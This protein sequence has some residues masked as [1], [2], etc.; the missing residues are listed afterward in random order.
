MTPER[1]Q[2][3][4]A[5]LHAA[6]A[7]PTT[8]RGTYLAGACAGDDDLLRE[9]ESLLAQLSQGSG[10][11]STPAL[12]LGAAMPGRESSLVGRQLGRYVVQER[13]GSGGMGEVYRAEDTQLR[14]TVALKALHD[15][16]VISPEGRQRLLREAQAVAALNHPNIAAIYDLINI[17]SDA[18][19]PPHIVMEYVPGETLSMRLKRGP[20]HVTEALRVGREVADALAAT[21]KRGIIHRD[22]KPANLQLTADGRVKV[23][24]FGLAR[25][26]ASPVDTTNFTTDR[27]PL[28][29]ADHRIAGTPGYMSPEQA[30]GRPVG[31]PTDVF[32]LGIVLFEMLTGHRPY[33]GEEVLPVSLAMIS[34][35]TPQVQGRR[36]EFTSMIDALVTRMLAIE[37]GDR[38]TAADI[39]S[40]FD[41]LLR[42]D[43]SDVQAPGTAPRR[44]WLSSEAAV[45]AVAMILATAGVAWWASRG[46]APDRR[47]AIAV[48]PLVNL[49]GDATQDYIGIGI[50]ET[51]TTS[52]ARVRSV[53]VISR[54]GL[55]DLPR[56]SADARTIAR[57]VGATLVL[58]G[59]V[60]TSGDRMRVNAKLV[61]P[62]GSV[63]WAGE[64]DSPVIDLFTLQS[65]LAEA[66]IAG[67]SVSVSAA[68][69]Q[70]AV[71]PPT[72]NADA[73]QAYWQGLAFLDRDDPR[74]LSLAIA[75]LEKATMLDRQF[76]V[77]FGTLGDAYRQL[78]GRTGETSLIPKA[79][80]AIERGLALDPDR[81]EVRMSLAALYGGT[82]RPADAADEFR[83]VL[84]R[85]P[86][87]DEAHRRLAAVLQ[88]TGKPDEALR[89][90]QLAATL[91]PEYWR[92][93]QSLGFFFYTQKRLQEAVT[94]FTRVV[95]IR[96]D[97]N[98]YNQRG[99]A[100]QALGNRAAARADY[101]KAIA[102]DADNAAAYSNLGVLS[103]EEKRYDDAARA[104]A[105]AIRL[106]PKRALYHRNL[107]DAYTKLT[108]KDEARAEYLTAIN[109]T[110]E[111]LGV[112]PTDANALSQL[113]VYEAKVGRA[114]DARRH[115]DD[116]VARNAANPD[117]LFRRG[118]VLA[119]IGDVRGAVSALTNA[120]NH[121]YNVGQLR[122]EDDLAGIAN[123]PEF[124]KLILSR[125]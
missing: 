111:T 48:L 73:L 87:N 95:A 23:L 17:T 59:S 100:L 86:D 51:L 62:D 4:Q 68:E 107:G 64:T 47:P 117:V 12:D 66:V 71:T 88:S 101:E 61:R 112:N 50:A 15:D 106:R 104:F 90:Y 120:V 28:S 6:M 67:L 30:L 44:R 114:S 55:A 98:S 24:D 57:D 125:P 94:A 99:G 65:R 20:L 77:A 84:A 70:T 29:L 91:R 19:T 113:A 76:A 41:S 56:G 52:L 81:T 14:R 79:T 45:A 33:P 26:V 109:L 110:N 102:L 54:T 34:T 121:G 93:Q 69:R 37:P 7:L 35:P 46:P 78:Y 8:D 108:R 97:S 63:A 32:S 103:F 116:A 96:Q 16:G 42:P 39:V 49:T 119:L 1:W 38:P 18:A 83:K 74:N 36:S 124:R 43:S 5:L 21:H 22:L 9:V 10:F 27:A 31:T 92:N 105:G 122:E 80:A 123:D 11:L 58:Q 13:L 115:A 118:V 53:S 72:R 40:E 89:E 82:G 2:Q 75:S 85:H 25:R 3:I 60:Q